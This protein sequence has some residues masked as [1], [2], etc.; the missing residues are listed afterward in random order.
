M[1]LPKLFSRLFGRSVERSAPKP[2]I[3][4]TY[5]TVRLGDEFANYW[6]HADRFDADSSH[7]R[8]VR[9]RLISHSR[10]ENANNPYADGIAQTY[11]TDLVGVGPMLRMQTA[12][13]AFN[14][15]VEN[16]FYHWMNDTNFRRKLWCMAHAKHTDGEAFGVLRF[17]PRSAHR[18]RLDIQLCEAEQVQTPH[19]PYGS[20]NYI[21]GIKFDRFGNALWYDVLREH[22]GTNRSVQLDYVPERVPADRMLHWFKMRRPGQ[23]R[24][25]PEIASSLN[26]GAAFRRM[27]EAV[28][29]AAETAADYSVFIKSGYSPE[30]VQETDPMESFEIEKRMAVTLPEGWDAFQMKSEHPNSTYSEFHKSLVNEQARPKNMPYNKAACDSS[31]YNYASGRLDHQT[32]YAALDVDREDCNDQVLNPLFRLWFDMAIWTYKWL[33]GDPELVSR[34]ASVHTW[35]WPKHRVADVEAEANANRTKLESGQIFVHRLFADGGLDW[36]DECQA[37]AAAYGVDVNEIKRRVLDALYPPPKPATNAKSND[38]VV[39]ALLSR[40]GLFQ[41]VANGT[42]HG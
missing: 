21:D 7:S 38:G 25:V 18:I 1:R 9:H 12:S 30:R 15:M 2:R 35:D 29:A 13:Q 22:P 33:G 26:T 20:E 17:N 19:L 14:Q 6:N 3:R 34:S 24:G 39:N 41:P 4:G 16:T 42:H 40:G 28:I 5:D 27:R 32:Y 37:A 8:D 23:H 10:Y 11:A 36:E 31:N